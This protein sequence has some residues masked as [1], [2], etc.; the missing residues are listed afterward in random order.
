MFIDDRNVVDYLIGVHLSYD[1]H[2]ETLGKYALH[3]NSS[4]YQEPKRKKHL[5][6]FL[7]DFSIFIKY[8]SHSSCVRRVA[9][10]LLYDE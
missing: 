9:L 1:K 4:A 7:V 8:K 5:V 10:L 3:N 6:E 2:N